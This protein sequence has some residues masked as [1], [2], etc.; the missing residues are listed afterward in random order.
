[1]ETY[2]DAFARVYNDPSTYFSRFAK[3]I[4]PRIFELHAARATNGAARALLDVGCGTGQLAQFFLENGYRVVGIDR[5]DAMLKHATENSVAHVQA[6]RAKFVKADATAFTLPD[7]FDLATATFDA[8]NHLGDLEEVKRCFR[9][10]GRVVVAGGLFVFDM[11]TELGLRHWTFVDA[12][13]TADHMIVNR[14][15]FDERASC[16]VMRVSGFIRTRTGLYE[17]FEE[18]LRNTVFAMEDI[19]RALIETGWSSVYFARLQ[20]LRRPI[21]RP[22][23]EERVCVVA[24]K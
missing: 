8:V 20:D 7:R 10:V 14:A 15:I 18:V 24:Q 6:G 9:C 23:E 21:D 17:R 13:D 3:G 4:A 11:N 12:R 5:A 22:E 2:G 1:M 19:R 16:A